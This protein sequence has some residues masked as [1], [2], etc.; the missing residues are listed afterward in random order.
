MGLPD[1]LV[2]RAKVPSRVV[3]VLA[4]IAA[5]GAF[6]SKSDVCLG[7]VVWVF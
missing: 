5:P 7:V 2:L 3:V 1:S 6:T 4:T